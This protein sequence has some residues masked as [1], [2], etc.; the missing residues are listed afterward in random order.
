MGLIVPLG[1]DRGV[2]WKIIVLIFIKK[3]TKFVARR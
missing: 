3:F 1:C 2:V